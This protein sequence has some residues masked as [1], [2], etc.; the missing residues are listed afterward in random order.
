[1]TLRSTISPVPVLKLYAIL[2]DRFSARFLLR[3]P[4][5]EAGLRTLV[6]RLE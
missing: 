5:R 4:L 3:V 6:F 2:N 1:M